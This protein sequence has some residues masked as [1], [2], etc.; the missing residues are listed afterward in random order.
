M[1][2]SMMSSWLLSL[3]SFI[4]TTENICVVVTMSWVINDA[5]VSYG[6]VTNG[7]LLLLLNI[8]AS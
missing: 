3:S 1:M 7:A 5:W 8:I 4:L 2:V 6:E